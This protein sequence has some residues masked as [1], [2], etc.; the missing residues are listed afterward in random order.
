MAARPVSSLHSGFSTRRQFLS[1]AA[2]GGAALL[3]PR[4]LRGQSAAPARDRLRLALVGVGGRGGAALT[5]LRE[6][7]FV[8]FCDVDEVR[9]RSEPLAHATTGPI[10]AQF[11]AARWFKDYREMFAAMADRID[12]VVV[13]TPD[14][15]HFAI[16]MA[17]ISHRKHL[18]LEKPLCRCLTEVR[19]L[20]AAARKAGV[21]TQMGNQG[22]AGEGIRTAREWVEAGLL[23][24]VHTVHAWTDRPRLPW[25][26]PADFDP[27][28]T[29][30]T[31]PVPP[32]LDWNLWLGV[33]PE[34]P[35]RAELT[36]ELW[37][38]YVDY[39]CGSLGDM[40]CHQVEAAF[41][42]LDLG[43]PTSVEAATT[44]LYP[45]SFPASTAVTWKFPARPGRGAVELRW[46]DGGLLPPQPVPGF[47]FAP[48]GGSIFYG[49][50]G[51]MVV[52]SHSGSARL[53]PDER[54]N[55]LRPS[56]PPKTIPRVHGGSHQEWARAIR[57]GPACGS[58]FDYAAPLTE[59][60]LLGVAA[61]RAQARLAWDAGAARFS[62]RPDADRF[63]GPGYPYR[64]G[65]QV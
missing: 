61:I 49:T 40:G 17:A 51:M 18:Y 22:R 50:E 37:R 20:Q 2:V 16:G 44:K 11:P 45:K 19:A 60:V 36:P 27:D 8:A 21:I 15:M 31:T 55:A 57:G 23:G 56:L 59:V 24:D 5:A 33:A 3:L 1:H 13:A 42:A 4:T 63:L 35:Y 10:L 26:R 32:T 48:D 12:A 28:A 58:H 62:N 54:M 6:E 34:R 53:L 46:F 47:K 52:S 29:D 39:G 25:F 64:P 14:H 41:Y 65:W 38:G 7:E 9:G 43:A 30:T